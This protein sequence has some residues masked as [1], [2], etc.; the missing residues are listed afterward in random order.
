M[1][2]KNDFRQLN[3]TQSV[4]FLVGGILMVVGM[5]FYVFMLWRDIA[6]AVFLL[7]AVLFSVMQCIQTYNG[8]SITLRRLKNIMT[9]ADLLFVLSGVLMID[10]ATQ[11]LRPMFR[12][13]INYIEY[14]YNKWLPLLMIAVVLEVYTTHRISSEIKKQK[15]QE[16]GKSEKL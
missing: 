10:T 1:A 9:M 12:N 7:G 5:G 6:G 4:L 2:D 15:K 14:V 16:D 11:F 13:Q 3:G 8:T